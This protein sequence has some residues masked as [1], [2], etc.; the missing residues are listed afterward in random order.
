MEEELASVP[1][2]AELID[3][4]AAAV[5]ERLVATPSVSGSEARAC[6]VFVE[7]ARAL[8]LRAGT[9]EVGNAVAERGPERGAIRG[10]FRGAG[11]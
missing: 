2:D 6:G 11:A 1:R 7:A 5:L 4:D 8:G 3:A 9:D 10:A